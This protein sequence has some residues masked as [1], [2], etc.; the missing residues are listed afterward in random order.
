[1][2]EEQN[3]R[4]R[5]FWLIRLRWIG[6]ITLLVTTHLFKEIYFFEFSLIPVY[7]ILGFAS[8]YN[9]VFN[10]RLKRLDLNLKKEV[11][12]NMFL[13]QLTLAGAVYFSGGCD[14]PFIYF[15]IFHV[16]IG[17]IILK[18]REIIF[19]TI[20]AFFFPKPCDGA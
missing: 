13:D 10:K 12:F 15:F 19:I 6:I 2:I 3:L 20:S 1:M 4:E 5:L 16:V 18:P 9:L 14:S 7:S 17:G 11:L 8:L